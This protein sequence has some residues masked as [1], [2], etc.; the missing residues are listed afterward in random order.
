MKMGMGVRIPQLPQKYGEMVKW[1]PPLRFKQELLPEENTTSDHK[2]VS[3]EGH[4]E[5]R[6]LFSP[7]K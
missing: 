1:Q 7:Q 4:I 2:S 3:T 5:V 6:P